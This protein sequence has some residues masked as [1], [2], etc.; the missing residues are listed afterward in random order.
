MDSYVLETDVEPDDLIAIE[1]M[2]S[3]LKTPIKITF[4]IGEG[5]AVNIYAKIALM[6][7]FLSPM[8]MFRDVDVIN[9]L[10]SDKDYPLESEI[11]PQFNNNVLEQYESVYRA[12]P[13]YAYMMKPPRE[14]FQL[15]LHCPDTEVIMYGGFNLRAIGCGVDEV[16]AFMHRYGRFTYIDSFRLIG[17]KNSATYTGSN[18]IIR[19][20]VQS[21][22]AHIV[23][24]M[25]KGLD[26]LAA[27]E[28]SEKKTA[29]IA[30]KQKVIVSVEKDPM[31]FVLADVLLFSPSMYLEPIKVTKV[32]PYFECM[33]CEGETVFAPMCTDAE[34]ELNREEILK[35]I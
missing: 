27:K 17:E 5:K 23:S 16:D 12:K 22:N 11:I 32:E 2:H 35:E 8:T 28:D 4:I 21:W 25:K 10:S 14:A 30:R 7:E 18:K 15:K 33:H 24:D 20:L 34:K 6:T 26:A 13:K 3:K 31:Q 1:L 9:G 29:S 19:N